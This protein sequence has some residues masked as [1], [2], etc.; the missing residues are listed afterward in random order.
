[1]LISV[2][3]KPSVDPGKMQ[4]LGIVLLLIAAVSESLLQIVLKKNTVP[5][6]PMK[7]NSAQIFIGGATLFIISIPAEGMM[8]FNLPGTF[9]ISLLWLSLVSAIGFSIWYGLIQNP[10]MRVSDLNML[11]F[12]NP[13]LGAV[14]S[15]IVMANDSPDLYSVIGMLIISA[16][17]LLF[18]A[19]KRTRP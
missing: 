18:Y 15:W 11:K 12:L 16:A 5:Y 3:R 8:N 9:Y 14:L 4:V 2:S 10:R 6:D 19:K 1:M 7:L 13:V 17:V